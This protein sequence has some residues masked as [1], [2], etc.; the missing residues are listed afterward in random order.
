MSNFSRKLNLKAPYSLLLLNAPAQLVPLFEEE[1]VTVIVQQTTTEQHTFDAVQ[2]FVSSKE[3]LDALAPQAAGAL[4]IGGIFWVA[5]P[6][7]SSGIKSDLTRDHGWQTIKEMGYEGVRQVALDD[8]WSSLRFK[9]V[10]E[11]TQPSKMGVDYPGIDRKTKT[12]TLPPDLEKALMEN[13]LLA[14]FEAQA[15]TNRKELVIAVLDA[16]RPETREKRINKTIELLQAK[17]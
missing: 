9:H 13:N 8:T 2:L 10:S 12:V 17:K 3:E 7:K 6:K 16:K 15:F 5:Y 4:K 1:G 14:Q 11:R